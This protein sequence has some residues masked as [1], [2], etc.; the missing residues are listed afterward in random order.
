MSNCNKN[1]FNTFNKSNWISK[2]FLVYLNERRNISSCQIH[3]H[4]PLKSKSIKYLKPN[5]A[6]KKRVY[7]LTG[8]KFWLSVAFIWTNSL[9][10]VSC[11]ISKL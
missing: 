10:D 5:S 6:S 11:Q 4:V 1:V 8:L 2:Q 9:E 7:L 3:I